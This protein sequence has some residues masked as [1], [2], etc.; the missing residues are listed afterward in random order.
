MMR[1]IGFGLLLARGLL[2]VT[3]CDNVKSA[4]T[5]FASSMFDNSKH[6]FGINDDNKRKIALF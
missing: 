4:V 5:S 3:V 1:L 2:E 6:F